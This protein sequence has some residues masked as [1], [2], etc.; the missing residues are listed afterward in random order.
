M[1]KLL[2]AGASWVTTNPQFGQ[3]SVRTEQLIEC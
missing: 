1:R 2:A 3:R